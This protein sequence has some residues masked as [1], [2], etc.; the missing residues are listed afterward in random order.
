MNH[1][2]TGIGQYTQHLLAAMAKQDP[3]ISWMVPVPEPV[4]PS[5]KLPKSVHIHVLPEFT[6]IPSSLSKWLWEQVQVP[7]FFARHNLDL[8]HYPYPANPRYK[9][10]VPSLVTV[11]DIIPWKRPEYRTKL[12]SRLYHHHAQRALLKAEEIIAVSQTTAFDLSDHLDYPFDHIKI[13]HEAASPHFGFKK[14]KFKHS[15][16]YFLYVGGY[17]PRKNVTRLIEAYQEYIAPKYDVDLILM[18]AK[19]AQKDLKNGTSRLISPL[20]EST[21]NVSHPGQI[22]LTDSLSADDLARYYRGALAFVNVS[23]AEG[24]N[25]PLLESAACGTPILTSDLPIHREIVQDHGRFCDP[26]Q[27]KSIGKMLLHFLQNQT[28]QSDLRDHAAHLATQYS[29]EK[30]ATQTLEFYRSLPLN[31][32]KL[33]SRRH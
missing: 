5:I 15:K 14:G 33:T 7:R 30:A 18:G 10:R 6:S 31:H 1:P 23:L 2:Y 16:P 24:F 4:S 19:K 13:I 27:T 20:P 25:L 26:K 21:I 22:I 8:I 28:L 9:S 29:W 3:S 32:G 12:R 17:D 11:H